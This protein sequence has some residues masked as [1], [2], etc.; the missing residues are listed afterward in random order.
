MSALPRVEP[1][2]DQTA[3][4][5]PQIPRVYALFCGFAKLATRRFEGDLGGRLLLYAPFDAEGASIAL[6]ANLA[7][8]AT[9]GIDSDLERLR[10]G[11]RRGFCDFVVNHLDEAVR[12]LKNEIR[13]KQ[14]VS[15]CLEG[16]LDALVRESVAR[17]LQP[18]LVALPGHLGE[19]ETFAQRGAMIVPQGLESI[20]PRQPLNWSAQSASALWL[21]KVDALAAQLFP[22]GD[23]RSRWLK[24]APRYLGREL[25]VRHYVEMTGEEADR[26]STLVEAAVSSGLIGTKITLD[27]L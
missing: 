10:Q 27:R 15:V 2:P 7:G 5:C 11:L 13:K 23:E 14:P 3:A 1:T 8:A 19:G 17:G 16:G 18:D 12:I 4:D 24:L 26:F 25:A 20:P 22:A 9:L 6:A 21:P